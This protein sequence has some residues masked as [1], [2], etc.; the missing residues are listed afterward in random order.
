M[1]GRVGRRLFREDGQ[2]DLSFGTKFRR[3]GEGA[4]LP[5]ARRN[6]VWM[7]AFLPQEIPKLLGTPLLEAVWEPVDR[8]AERVADADPA[9]RAM[10]LDQRLYLGEGVL[11]KVDRAGMLAGV[12]FRAPFVD[13]HLVALAASLPGHLKLGPRRSKAGLKDAF[14]KA[15]PTSTLRRQKKGF[16][17]PIGPWL[18]G[19]ARPALERFVQAPGK[20][21]D[22]DYLS[23]L[24]QEHWSGEADN[25]R[26]LWSLLLLSA[27]QQGTWG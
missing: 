17:T 16:G 19:A 18:Q 22:P 9:Q 15:L 2:R 10:Y 5:W 1:L 8:W 4:G 13:H 21:V 12:E 14:R 26:R 20:L 27:W 24:C 6:Q 11:Q 23:H 25:R 7:G 3:F